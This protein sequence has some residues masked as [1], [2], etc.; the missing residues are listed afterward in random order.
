MGGTKKGAGG[1]YLAVSVTINE[2]GTFQ[3]RAVRLRAGESA[4][5]IH[6]ID[7]G[8]VVSSGLVTLAQLL[9]LAARDLRVAAERD[10][11]LP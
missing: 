9:E 6:H 4:V 8:I 5:T 2:D 1:N 10:G 11:R 7:S 3:T